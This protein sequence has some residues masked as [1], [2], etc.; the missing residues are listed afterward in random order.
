MSRILI[1]LFFLLTFV[2][3]CATNNICTNKRTSVVCETDPYGQV[4]CYHI[5]ICKP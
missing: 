1:L 2:S 5:K 3:S 4:N